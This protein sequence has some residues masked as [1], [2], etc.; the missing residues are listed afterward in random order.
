MSAEPQYESDAA[1]MWMNRCRRY[2][3]HMADNVPQELWPEFF[4]PPAVT[5]EQAS[6]RAAQALAFAYDLDGGCMQRVV[7]RALHIWTERYKPH[8]GA[9]GVSQGGEP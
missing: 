1:A 9:G 8:A 7:V 2:E 6:E 4:K 5:S 3:Q